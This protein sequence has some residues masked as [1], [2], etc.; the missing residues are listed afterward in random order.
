VVQKN[1]FLRC[2]EACLLAIL[3]LL[4]INGGCGSGSSGPRS[5]TPSPGPGRVV[6]QPGWTLK[7]SDEPSRQQNPK[8]WTFL[9]YMNGANDLE[10]FGSLNMNQMEQIGTTADINLVVQFKRFANRYDRSNGDWGDTRR[11]QVTKDSDNNWVG[12]EFNSSHPNKDMGDWTSLRE[13]I[14]WGMAVYPAEKYCLVLWN[15]G[16][17]WR[18]VRDTAAKTRGFSY[19]DTTDNHIDT[20]QIPQAIDLE[21]ILGAGRKWDIVAFDSSLMQM[22]EVAHEIRNKAVYITGSEESPPGEGY[23]YHLFL[24]DLANNPTMSARDFAIKIVDRTIEQYGTDS[25]ITHSVLDASKIGEVTA[26]TNQLGN[27]LLN[28][29]DIYRDQIVFAR[30]T[31]ENYDYPY[32]RDIL[33]F[34]GLISEPIPGAT[35][36]PIPDAAVQNAAARVKNAVQ[37]AVIRSVNGSLHPNSTGLSIFLPS[38]SQ[39][40]SLDIDQANGF[41]QRYG[42]LTFAKD[43]P[44]WQSFL[45]DGPR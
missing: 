18:K 39:Y 38:P 33:D 26:A 19:D 13:F 37:A 36:P 30:N 34:V 25:N 2:P 16:A 21:G 15:H 6:E 44:N 43:A 45:V 28:V 24:R 29:K 32:Y 22:A 40:N 23:P 41:G 12:T 8:K 31:A 35:A 11:F 27:A 4:L 7:K 20:I 1:V 42:E 9:V 5:V 14:Q 17:G 3:A 10:E